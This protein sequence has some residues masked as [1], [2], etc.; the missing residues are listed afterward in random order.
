VSIAKPAGDLRTGDDLRAALRTSIT[1]TL[2]QRGGDVAL[3]LPEDRAAAGGPAVVLIV[4]VNGAG[5]TTT[6][7]KLAHKFAATGAAVVLGSGDT[8]RAAA[9]EQLGEWA[10]R[11]GATMGPYNEADSSAQVLSG[12]VRA[13]QASGADLVLCD[14]SG[15][16]H[17]N[18]RL[19]DEL[20]EVEA[21]LRAALPG[22]PHETLLVLDGSTG[23]N[24]TNQARSALLPA[25]CM[26]CSSCAPRWRRPRRV[27]RSRRRL[28]ARRR[29]D[30]DDD[31][32][33]DGDDDDDDAGATSQTGLGSRRCGDDA[34][35]SCA[36][37]GALQAS[38][39]PDAVGI[40]R[41]SL[42]TQQGAPC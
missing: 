7:G 6:V 22:S 19:M 3:R 9:Y 38:A 20:Q 23:L 35:T 10:A 42:R 16:L 29:G 24:M 31:D 8:F 1:E 12:T 26:L 41:C 25:A 18:W 15:R 28:R 40:A 34:A 33:D 13:A 37:V 39:C 21:A 2:T 17:T 4:G 11:A 5:K 30:D 27:L 32:D 14:T 36:G